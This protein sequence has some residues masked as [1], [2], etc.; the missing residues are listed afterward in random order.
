MRARVLKKDLYHYGV[1]CT[2]TVKHNGTK[3]YKHTFNP[4]IEIIVDDDYG[5]N[6]EISM[7]DK[8]GDVYTCASP[9]NFSIKVEGQEEREALIKLFKNILYELEINEEYYL[10]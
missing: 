7:T 10:K 4:F 8:C 5:T 2:L 3:D 1:G 9:D 6:F